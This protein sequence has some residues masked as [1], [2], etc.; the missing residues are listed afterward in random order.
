[1]KAQKG[2]CRCCH[3]VDF[4]KRGPRSRMVYY[5]FIGYGVSQSG[6]AWAGLSG[7]EIMVK[8]QDAR[9]IKDIVCDAS[10][11]TS[12]GGG[13][14][15]L[16]K[17]KWWRKATSDGI[18]YATLTRFYEPATIRGEGTLFVDQAGGVS[19]ILL[20]LPNFKKVRRVEA[21]AQR[22]SFMQS[23]L[24]YADIAPPRA[25]DYKNRKVSDGKCPAPNENLNCVVVESEP[26]SEAILESTG[27][28]KTVAWVRTDN[29]MIVQ[30]EHYDVNGVLSK[31]RIV[32]EIREVD[33]ILHKYMA[34]KFR[35]DNLRTGRFTVMEFKNA[36][37]NSGLPDSLFTQQNLEKGRL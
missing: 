27:Y 11:L 3:S 24:S 12:G 17:F 33:P 8:H 10:L 30:S 16:R 18:H 5:L 6:F 26:G 7:S 21:Q 29:W 34:F 4:K 13:Q 23:E 19:D 31:R 9:K 35:I 37:V 15:H 25:E 1:M 22:G 28:T 20:Y 36:T 32:S 14:E 2:P